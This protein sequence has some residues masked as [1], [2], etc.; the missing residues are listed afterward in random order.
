VAFKS[1]ATIGK[2]QSTSTYLG[3]PGTLEAEGRHD[4]CVVPRAVPIVEAMAALVIMDALSAQQSIE[5]SK[6][7]LSR[8]LSRLDE[9]PKRLKRQQEQSTPEGQSGNDS[10]GHSAGNPK[11]SSAHQKELLKH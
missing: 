6:S 8:A 7:A 1:P 11:R 3:K 2:A 5:A 4:P 9:P 10:G